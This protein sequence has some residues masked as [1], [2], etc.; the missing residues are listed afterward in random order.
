[1]RRLKRLCSPIVDEGLG[2]FF[3]NFRS[4]APLKVAN[5]QHPARL[6]LALH[7]FNW[8]DVDA[9]ML[10]AAGSALLGAMPRSDIYRPA[11]VQADFYS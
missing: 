2:Q 9:P 11:D 7:S 8:P 1:M 10:S 5:T 4:Q 3:E 6:A